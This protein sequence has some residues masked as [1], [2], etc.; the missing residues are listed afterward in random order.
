VGRKVAVLGL[1]VACAAGLA[2]CSSSSVTTGQASSST[3]GSSKTSSKPST[4]GGAASSKKSG[5]GLNPLGTTVT[6]PNT[7]S[8]ID[9]VT[10]SAFYPNVTDTSSY[11]VTPPAGHVWDAI[12]ATTCA[13]PQGSSTGPNEEDFS[14]LL[15]NGSTAS[16]STTASAAQF[17]GA[18][19]S[20]SELGSSLS[21]LTPGQC[22]TGWIA[23]TV[24]TTTTPTA[25]EF[26]GTSASFTQPD[27]VVKWALPAS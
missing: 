26:S 12:V 3:S 25:V 19:S 5:S 27:S 6:I 23:F 17:G 16:V 11:P 14:L 22:V 9:K 8:G 15:N 21:G 18:L 2:A 4:T 20:L 10:V 13:G 1:S 7:L 24:P